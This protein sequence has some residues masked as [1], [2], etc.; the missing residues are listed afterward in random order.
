MARRNIGIVRMVRGRRRARFGF[1]VIR[2]FFKGRCHGLA[3]LIG[4]AGRARR[5]LRGQWPTYRVQLARNAVSRA[6]PLQ[7]AHPMRCRE[8]RRDAWVTDPQAVS[9]GAQNLPQK[10]P[11]MRSSKTDGSNASLAG[12]PK[13]P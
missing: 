5:E 1:F 7:A 3:M 4:R 11:I 10:S 9:K 6:H 13:K 2:V 12:L 8:R